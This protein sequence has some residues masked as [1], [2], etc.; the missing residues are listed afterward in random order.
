M[1]RR[2]GLIWTLTHGGV[3]SVL[4]LAVAAAAA[5]LATRGCDN[6]ESVGA[7]VA[8]VSLGGKSFHL[9]LALDQET[10]FKGLS[11]RTFI[12]PDGGML[13]VFTRPLRLDFVMRDCPI[14]IDIVFLDGSGRITA[15]HEMTPEPPRSEVEKVIDP[16]TGANQAY[17]DR[18]KRYSS[19]FDAQFVIEI[20]GGTLKTLNLKRGDKVNLDVAALKSRAK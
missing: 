18:L 16:A 6:K 9:E 15:T 17:E 11:G 19:G 13:F 3:G 8:T 10:R 7:A 4:L 1:A 20:R 5:L 2:E 12:E 14:P